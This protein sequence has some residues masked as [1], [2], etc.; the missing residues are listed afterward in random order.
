MVHP[1]QKFRVA[2][3]AMAYNPKSSSYLYVSLSKSLQWNLFFRGTASHDTREDKVRLVVNLEI[4][5]TPTT[6][7]RFYRLKNGTC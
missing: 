1:R 4:R 3:S 6:L 2:F 7:C 5:H